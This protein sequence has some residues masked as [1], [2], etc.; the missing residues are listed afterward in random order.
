[1]PYRLSQG[2]LRAKT[3]EAQRLVAS[4]QI[5]FTE[6]SSEGKFVRDKVRTLVE[7][8]RKQAAKARAVEG[9]DAPV[10]PIHLAIA[11]IER[12]SQELHAGVVVDIQEPEE[13]PPP[14]P[15]RLTRLP[16][17]CPRPS[18]KKPRLRRASTFPPR[19]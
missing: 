2:E 13:R 9:Q 16:T 3:R 18:P 17:R 14:P 7:Q 1:M 6:D 4:Q 8:I 5:R 12:L 11:L 10:Q 19:S 15:P